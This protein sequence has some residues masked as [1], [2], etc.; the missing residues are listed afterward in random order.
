MIK[1]KTGQE[2]M[3]VY[4]KALELM[5]G[6]PI[7]FRTLLN[8]IA[9]CPNYYENVVVSAMNFLKIDTTLSSNLLSFSFLAGLA[10]LGFLSPLANFAFLSVKFKICLVV[11]SS[12]IVR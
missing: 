2:P 5:E 8:G 1:E 4:E 12:L 3:E 6:K 9:N 11:Y 7:T 10:C